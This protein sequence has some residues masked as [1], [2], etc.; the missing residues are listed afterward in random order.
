MK[1]KALRLGYFSNRR[2]DED[3]VFEIK[4]LQEFSHRWMQALDF[5]PPAHVG[6]VIPF[7]GQHLPT[8]KQNHSDPVPLSKSVKPTGE[9]SVI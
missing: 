5:E 7:L 2:M 9:R 3:E 4:D 1:V 8:V 6:P